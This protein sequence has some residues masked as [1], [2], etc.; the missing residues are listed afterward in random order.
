MHTAGMPFTMAFA[1][2]GTLWTGSEAICCT[3]KAMMD[4]PTKPVQPQVVKRNPHTCTYRLIPRGPAVSAADLSHLNAYPAMMA[5]LATGSVIVKPHPMAYC[6][7][8]CSQA[9][10]TSCRAQINPQSS[11][12]LNET[13]EPMTLE[14]IEHPSSAIVDFTGSPKFGE[15]IRPTLAC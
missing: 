4:V 12:W 2:A 9:V 5:N 1:G 11:R 3:Y 7:W 6:P 13:L 15:W 8:F 10:K 14:L